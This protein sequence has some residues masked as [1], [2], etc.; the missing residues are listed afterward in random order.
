MTFI[1]KPEIT[2]LTIRS[3]LVALAAKVEGVAGVESIQTLEKLTE[4]LVENTVMHVYWSS[5][6]TDY[7]TA[8]SRSTF[9][10]NVRQTRLV[11][12]YDIYDTIMVD[13]GE[14]VPR[15]IDITDIVQERLESEHEQPFFGLQGI[16]DF[17]WSAEFITLKHNETEYSGVRFEIEMMVF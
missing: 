7:A 14:T 5:L 12:R 9:K 8:S 1:A 11:F 4:G 13:V 17:N 2:Q 3:I 6:K 16:K 15:L 10:G